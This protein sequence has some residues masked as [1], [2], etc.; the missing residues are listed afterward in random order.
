MDVLVTRFLPGNALILL[1]QQCKID[2]WDKPVSIPRD[3]LLNRI[4]DKSG[5]LCM[6][7]DIIDEE[8]MDISPGLKVISNYAVGYNNIDIN[9]ANKRGIVVTNTPDV[10]TNATA[11]LTWALIFSVARRIVEADMFARS[12]SWKAWDPNLMLGADVYGQT[13]GII[14]AGRIGTAVALRSKGFN[15][16]VV[17]VSGFS[18]PVIENHL[19]AKRMDLEDLLKVSDFVSLHVPLTPE[20][21]HMISTSELSLMKKSAFL[22][23][24]SRGSVVDE[25]ALVKALEGGEIAG[26][27]LDVFEHEP[28]IPLRLSKLPNVVLLPHIGSATYEA[29]SKMAELAVEN[30]LAVLGGKTPPHPV[31]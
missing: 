19:R 27:G 12:L 14:G 31:T 10:L 23:N 1:S 6:L 16:H 25:L 29:R 30:I 26:A 4:K 11:D 17:Y 22:I 5:L 7:T 24:T 15:M 18:N 9:A 21:T 2:L 20:T 13:L 8:I 28:A 3:E